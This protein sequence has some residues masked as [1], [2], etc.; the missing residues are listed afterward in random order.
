MTEK[1]FC[2]SLCS[3]WCKPVCTHT[4]TLFH[5]SLS[6]SLT[7]ISHGKSKWT[8]S[9]ASF[10]VTLCFTNWSHSESTGRKTKRDIPPFFPT[11]PW[12]H[13]VSTRV[14]AHSSLFL[15]PLNSQL[16][17]NPK[18]VIFLGLIFIKAKPLTPSSLAPAP[19][20]GDSEVLC[21]LIGF[22]Y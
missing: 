6:Q 14:C 12:P 10:T 21:L 11:S 5:P 22:P 1:F 7:E 8:P 20:R 2:L 18:V 3:V 9:S 17:I 15:F 19:P 13:T 4:H 16:L